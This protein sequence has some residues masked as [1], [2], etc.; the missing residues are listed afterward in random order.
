[1][2]VKVVVDVKADSVTQEISFIVPALFGPI[3]YIKVGSTWKQASAVYIKS[4]GAWKEE[5][6]KI[7]VGGAWK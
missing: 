1:M 2:A 3:V 5:Q 7:N 6:L 4:S